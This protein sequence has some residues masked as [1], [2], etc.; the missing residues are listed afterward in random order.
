MLTIKKTLPGSSLEIFVT[1]VCAFTFVV[2]YSMS[3]LSVSIG[4]LGITFAI[5][6][7]LKK[8]EY[9]VFFL[10]LCLPFRDIHLISAIHFKRAMIWGLFLYSVFRQIA[11]SHRVISADVFNFTRATLFFV[12][13]LVLSL[14]KTASA[15][16]SNI[17]VTGTMLKSSILSDALFVVEGLLIVYVCY[18]FLETLGHVRQLFA[19]IMANS[20]IVSLLGIVQ[21]YLGGPPAVLSFLY[22]P[23]Y[24][25][26]GRA[27]SVFSN[28]NLLGGFLAPIIVMTVISLLSE[29]S[30][31]KRVL[32]LL[33]ALLLNSWAL[34]LSFSRGA[35]LQVFF[36]ILIA[37]YVYYM[38]VKRRRISWKMMLAA[39]GMVGLLLV[40]IQ[41]YDWYLRARVSSNT[42]QDYRTAVNWIKS[43]SDFQRK[44]S[45][46]A[47]F[48][49]FLK[50]PVLGIGYNL[51]SGQR[52]AGYEYF[53]LAVHNQYLELLAEMG[54]LGFFPF[55]VLLWVT[56]KAGMRM[57]SRY[58]ECQATREIQFLMLALLA[59]IS[60]VMLGYLFADTLP[61]LPITG[62]LWVLCGAVFVLEQCI[63]KES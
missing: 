44:H 56:T 13:M 52:A 62:S 11:L 54:L 26:Y 53:G 58:E 50:H 10:V 60:A 32:F 37:I 18:C 51:Y 46:I 57:W 12:G 47:A 21:Y 28:P 16:N 9:A 33:P 41:G 36:G 31:L 43:T 8:P 1:V 38:Y 24:Q 20:A 19:L 7:L 61:F 55:I 3:P 6:V 22:D 14:I 2:F 25:F 30:V 40:A 5:P 23:E 48:Q 15:V 4:A 17:Y 45:A 34:L 63:A 29:Q 27:T 39:I 59:G 42:G 35:I 49:T